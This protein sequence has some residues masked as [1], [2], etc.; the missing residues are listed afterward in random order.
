AICLFVS[1]NAYTQYPS[2]R[3]YPSQN[4][5]IEPSIVV[6]PVNP[7]IM[8]ASAFT[9]R[10]S[11]KSEGIYLTTNGGMNWTG[12]DTC[13][14]QP[15]S[16]HG[17]DPGPIIDKD[18][19]LIITHQGGFILGMYSNTSTNFGQTWSNNY[20]IAGNDQ[21]KGSPATD[22]V[23]SS[24]FYGRTFLVWTRFTNPFP[25]V[26][27][28]TT[29]SGTNWTAVSQINNSLPQRQSTGPSMVI[30]TDGTN[31]VTWASSLLSSPF[32]EKNIG[33]AV[34]SNGG[35][36]WT[37]NEN[38]YACNGV[39]SSSLSPW[40]IRVNGFPAM[41]IDKSGGS[42]NDWLYIV[43]SEKNLLP[44]GTDPDIVFHRSSDRGNSWSQG[45]RI[46]Q[47]PINNGKNQVFPAITVDG[48]GGINVVYLDNRN[49]P[50][51]AQIYLSRS[52]N[53][54]D[55]WTDYIVSDHKFLPKSLSG[56]GAGNQGDNIG[57]TH[58]NNKLFPVWNDDI[59]GVYQVWTAPI[60]LNTIGIIQISN[61]I[62]DAYSLSQNFP[63][64]FNPGTIIKFD[65]TRVESGET[66]DTKLVVYDVTG[67]EV[68]T[69]VNEKLSPGSYQANFDG[70]NYPSGIYLYSLQTGNYSQTKRMILIK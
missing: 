59:T 47:D 36:N 41:D 49:S 52:T 31:Y 43:S 65:I 58:T 66:R 40:N 35:A 42:R 68:T 27:S 55:N 25:I 4:N 24:P 9:I 21:D 38:V 30:G 29:N 16:N 44:A 57:I 54:G 48:G 1:V 2:F 45:K 53:G 56:A 37:V 32:N 11:F 60:D 28:Y 14:G 18:G 12:T 15:L 67:K 23:A 39:K 8:F 34:S 70:R 50:D 19:N 61:E 64:P 63:N 6:H 26:L 10:L 3:L 33:I 51:S 13:N 7:N 20:Q 22:N 5:Q 62:P 17:G 46:N 69:L